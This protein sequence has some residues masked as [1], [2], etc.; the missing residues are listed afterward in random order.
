MTKFQAIVDTVRLGS[1]GLG[2]LSG[3]GRSN[4]VDILLKKWVYA[5]YGVHVEL[6][7]KRWVYGANTECTLNTAITVCVSFFMK[8]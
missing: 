6:V 4:H 7:K 2:G 8:Q 3:V 1:M 5:K